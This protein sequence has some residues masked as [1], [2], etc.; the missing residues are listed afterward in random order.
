MPFE[1]FVRPSRGGWR[2]TG[3]AVAAGLRKRADAG[4]TVG[5]LPSET[6]NHVYRDI[7]QWADEG[8]GWSEIAR[9]LNDRGDRRAKGG[10][11]TPATVHKMA[12]SRT[13]ERLRINNT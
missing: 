4:G 3:G 12:H 13:A 6:L 5:R 2:A 9:L 8:K 1:T 7:I 11:F 10:S